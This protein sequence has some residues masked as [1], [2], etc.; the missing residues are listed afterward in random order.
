MA[1]CFLFFL[2]VAKRPGEGKRS[3]SGVP[4]PMGESMQ[5][6]G[7]AGRRDEVIPPYGALR[8]ENVNSR[9]RPGEGR[10]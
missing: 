4:G 2:A 3:H 6:V 5:M 7:T 8:K 9:E 1:C 10:R